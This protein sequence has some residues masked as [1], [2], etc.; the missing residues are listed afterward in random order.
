MNT[1]LLDLRHAASVLIRRPGFTVPV[2]LTL[3]LGIGANTAIYSVVS[4]V[5][6]HP[7]PFAAAD[8]LMMVWETDRK[9]ET[10]R[11]PSSIPDYLDFQSRSR[12]F[13]VLSAL[14][15]ADVP[16]NTNS[17][18]P[19]RLAA[20]A[21]GQGMLPMTGVQ[22]LFGRTFTADEDRPG[23]P[24]VALISEALW[25]GQFA[26][27]PAIIGRDVRIN[28]VAHQ[29]IGVMAEGA[30]FGVL[31]VLG[32][33]AYGRGFAERG[34]RVRVDLWLPLRADPAASRG[35]HPILVV[36]RLAPG[37]DAAS[38]QH[39]MTAI[40]TD[41][42]RS[43]HDD[44]DGRGVHVEP[45]MDV[46]FGPVRPALLALLG[47]V[48]LV[49]LIACANVASLFLARG[50]A[51]LPEVAVRVALGANLRR[52]TQQ[53]IAES[54]VLT[55][56]GALAGVI[57]ARFLLDALLA[58][59]PA[60]I[61]RVAEVRLDAGVLAATAAVSLLVALVVGLLPVLQARRYGLQPSL[62]GERGAT[63]GRAHQQVRSVLVASELALAIMLMV[64]AGLLIRSLG[65]LSQVNPGFRAGGVLKAEFDLPRSRYPQD[66]AVYPHWTEI[67]RFG[68]DL[69]ARLAALP[70][71]RSVT[72]AGN[73]PLDAG[74][75]SSIAVVGREAEA[76]DW[77]EP[78]IRR[79]D[80]G[81]FATMEL[82]LVEGR[83]FQDADG[84]DATPVILINAAARR[85]Y[86]D[87]RAAL[88]SKIRLWGAERLVVGVVGD[89]RFQG[90]SNASP[91]AVYL[92]SAQAPIAGGSVL[93]RVQD[94][95]SGYAAS[96]RAAVH[97]VDPGLAVFGVEPLAATLANTLAQRRFT[98]S[99]L[100]IFAAAA[101]L[102]AIIGVHGVLSYTIAQ[103]AR[104][105]GIRMALGADT[106]LIRGLVLRQMARITAAGVVAGLAGALAVSRLIVVL[107][108]GVTPADP[109]TY[110]T[111]AVTLAI[112]ALLAGL[113][114]ARR[115]AMTDP[116]IA[117][118][119]E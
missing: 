83:Q 1:F 62:Q 36:G 80:A 77:P 82:P 81:Y 97:D 103:R 85:R 86:F 30:D 14:T 8:R 60:T 72:I 111:V 53:F 33:A 46:V 11:E 43:Y 23:A 78:A 26:A 91:P 25:R 58:L 5:L 117:L 115:A 108:F 70:G 47:A 13:A 10:T 35:N 73:H 40:A 84:S 9:S 48:A 69:R 41:L 54:L 75:T 63:A 45:L 107:L 20:L 31:Q 34:G 57:G 95:P 56:A 6:L 74:F 94:S 87:G 27:D 19:Q 18:E 110:V 101:L 59:A 3:A 116:A 93:I 100:G 17:G 61:P 106:R 96:V 15:A 28:D 109:V 79:I 64:G 104:E 4:G 105:F 98:M 38:A 67:Q 113:L 29:V 71:V 114:P 88:G 32:A 49:L 66:Y 39:E 99:V 92:P 119:S 44:N 21:V 90:L 2:V 102:L 12:R 55:A 22:P 68:T 89:E 42:E 24:R 65:E 50:V 51:R 52:L 37:A 118:R 16:L 112:V 76:G 7:T